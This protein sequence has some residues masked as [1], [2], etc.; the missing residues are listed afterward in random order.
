MPADVLVQ[1]TD[2]VSS[3]TENGCVGLDIHS[4]ASQPSGQD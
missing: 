2:L 4:Y 3:F 1:E